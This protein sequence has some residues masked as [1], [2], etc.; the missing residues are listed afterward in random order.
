M[1]DLLTDLNHSRGTTIVMVLHD[2]NLAAMFCDQ[3]AV[4]QKGEVVAAGPPEQVLTQELI[5]RVFGVRAHVQK[6]SVHGRCN[7]QYMAD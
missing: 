1:L 5:A 7:I 6:S 3:L 4:L 2:L